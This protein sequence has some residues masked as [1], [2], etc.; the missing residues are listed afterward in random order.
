MVLPYIRFSRTMTQAESASEIA[1]PLAAQARVLRLVIKHLQ[2]LECS[3]DS[4]MRSAA[5]RLETEMRHKL[6]TYEQHNPTQ[7]DSPLAS[8]D[9]A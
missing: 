5:S 9:R 4:E 3:G 8:L 6:K 1:M 2:A 7:I